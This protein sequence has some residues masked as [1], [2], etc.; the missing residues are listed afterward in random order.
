MQEYLPSK[1]ELREEEALMAWAGHADALLGSD[2]LYLRAQ[3]V[4]PIAPNTQDLPY[5]EILLGIR[6]I[7]GVVTGPYN[8]I[9]ALERMGRAH[10]L[11]L[12]VMRTAFRWIT[13]NWMILESIAGIAIN[14]SA[15]SL[16]NPEITEFLRQELT[17]GAF[18][19]SGRLVMRWTKTRG[20]VGSSAMLASTIAGC[21]CDRFVGSVRKSAPRIVVA[22]PATVLMRNCSVK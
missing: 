4:L 2:E 1:S 18:P 12:W 5:Y 11:D 3:L 16:P 6:P 8:F 21:S 22:S 13:E 14:L 15:S 17:R 7:G 9:V 20:S 19:A 10:E